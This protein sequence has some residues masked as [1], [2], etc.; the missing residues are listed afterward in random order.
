M[1][2]STTLADFCVKSRH[3]GH[4]NTCLFGFVDG[5]MICSGF[6]FGM[7]G[8]ASSLSPSCFANAGASAAVYRGFTGL[9]PFFKGLQRLL[10]VPVSL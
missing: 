3:T 5:G 8:S 4:M 10:R 1:W 7:V 6:F 2:A 9:S